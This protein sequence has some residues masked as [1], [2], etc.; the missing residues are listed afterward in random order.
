MYAQKLKHR[1]HEQLDHNYPLLLIM[2]TTTQVIPWNS[3][4]FTKMK[5]QSTTQH[6][7]ASFTGLR[8]V[9]IKNKYGTDH[10]DIETT[11]MVGECSV[12]TSLVM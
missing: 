4:S 8:L 5:S 3:L 10:P 2:N 12:M 7:W 1:R 11:N 6:V 9:Q